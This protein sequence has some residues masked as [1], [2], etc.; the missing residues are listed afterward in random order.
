MFEIKVTVDAPALASSIFWLANAIGG[1]DISGAFA[2]AE[3]KGQVKKAV[4]EQKDPEP[5]ADVSPTTTTAPSEIQKTDIPG[6]EESATQ[7]T[8]PAP[9]VQA[10][11]AQAP[12]ARP[13]I[14]KISNAGADL[15]TNGKIAELQGLLQQ[16]GLKTVAQVTGLDDTAFASFIAG[17]RALGAKI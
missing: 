6:T 17:L 15:C 12:E 1:G 2:D 9:E 13:S 8:S 16:Y 11:P 3:K 4:I 14:D 5:S 10:P 7:A